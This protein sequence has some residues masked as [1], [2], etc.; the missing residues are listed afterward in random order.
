[1]EI[2]IHARHAELAADFREIVESKLQSMERFSVIIDRVEVEIL[3][4][5]N[6]RQGK[7]SHRVILT[8]H[9][10][11][12]LLRAESAEFNDLAAFDEAIKSF[13][14]QVRKYHEKSKS[15]NR[16]TLRHKPVKE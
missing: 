10:T 7:H 13:D 4:E 1:M 2:I 15:Y 8:T 11:G 3:H 16:D 6:P 14:L 9:G 12:P 5:N